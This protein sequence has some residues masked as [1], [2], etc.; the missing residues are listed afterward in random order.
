[1]LQLLLRQ[2]SK[3]LPARFLAV[4]ELSE[5]QLLLGGESILR[6]SYM[7]KLPKVGSAVSTAPQLGS[8]PRGPRLLPLSG[9]FSL[10]VL[11]CLGAWAPSMAPE[12]CKTRPR[13]KGVFFVQLGGVVVGC[14]VL[15]PVQLKSDLGRRD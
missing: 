1:M 5:R 2:A 8:G 12:S 14:R 6:D 10:E 15:G 13:G 7:R 4:S 11:P 3:F 9:R